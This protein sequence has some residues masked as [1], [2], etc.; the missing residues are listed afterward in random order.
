[1]VG[2]EPAADPTHLE[3]HRAHAVGDDVV[4]LARDPGALLRYRLAGALLA[5]LL[6][7]GRVPLVAGGLVGAPLEQAAR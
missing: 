7:D 6:E 4:Q 2:R 3:H 5:L 1:M